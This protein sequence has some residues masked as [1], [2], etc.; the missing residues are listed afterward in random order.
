MIC[1]SIFLSIS[2]TA[3]LLTTPGSPVW[4]I[5]TENMVHPVHSQG[6]TSRIEP[7]SDIQPQGLTPGCTVSILRMEPW[8]TLG[9][10]SS[11]RI[12]DGPLITH[13][14]LGLGELYALQAKE[15]TVIKPCLLEKK[16]FLLTEI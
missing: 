8:E 1:A 9:S 14:S 13:C 2:Q 16:A 4:S 7:R 15:V 10:W 6:Q 3:T 12:G 5:Q 11:L